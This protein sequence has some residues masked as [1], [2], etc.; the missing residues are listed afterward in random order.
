MFSP[1]STILCSPSYLINVNFQDHSM[2]SATKTIIMNIIKSFSIALVMLGLSNCGSTGKTIEVKKTSGFQQNHGPFDANGNY[3]E[4]WADNAPKRKYVWKRPSTK[5]SAPT[6]QT[7]QKTAS[8]NTNSTNRITARRTT[9]KKTT[10]KKT[11][12]RKITP[13]AKPPIFHT[14]RKGDTLY[15][16]GRKY[17]TSV[18]A[19]QKANKIKGSNI[20]I[21]K[22]LIIPRK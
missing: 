13:K 17:G 7:N 16:L 19:I 20:G 21:G 4:K 18:T 2:K 3:V 6:Q 22:R 1:Q 12:A 5:K 8:N 11:T 14:V 15:G 10:S 9:P